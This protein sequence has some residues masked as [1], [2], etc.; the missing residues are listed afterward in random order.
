M[1][2]LKHISAP[3]VS[4]FPARVVCLLLFLLSGLQGVAAQEPSSPDILAGAIVLDARTRPLSGSPG[5]QVEERLVRTKHKYPLLRVE[6]RYESVGGKRTLV[7]RTASV[8]DHLMVKPRPGATEAEVLAEVGIAGAAVRKKM[9]TSGVWLVSFPASGVEGVARA[10]GSGKGGRKATAYAEPDHVVGASVVPNDPGFS[11]LWGLRN[12]GAGWGAAGVDIRATDAWESEAATGSLSVKVG[13]IDSGIDHTHPDLAENIWVNPNEI[14][15]NGIDDDNNGYIDDVRGWNFADGNNNAMD[16]NRHGTHVAG[17]IGGRGNNGAGV[18]GVCWRV[19][20][21]PLKFL[22]ADGTGNI[23]DAIEAVA[24]A[25]RLGVHLTNNSWGGGS[26]SQALKDVIDAANAAGILFVAAAGNESNDNDASP[27]YPASYAC[28]N[29]LSVAS[30]DRTGRLSR[31]SNYGRSTVHLGAP[32]G[33]I[34]STVP[35]G[36]YE[37]LSGTSMAAPHVAG[38]CALLKSR[39]PGMSHTQIRAKVLASARPMTALSGKTVTGAMLDAAAAV[40]GAL[41]VSYLGAPFSATRG[42]A[43]DP[44]SAPLTLV[45]N[46]AE[47]LAWRLVRKPEWLDAAPVSGQL[48]AGRSAAVVVAPNASAGTLP[49]G[50]TAGIVEFEEAASGARVTREVRVVVQPPAPGDAPRVDPVADRVVTQET[51]VTE[52]RLTGI[53][54]GQGT[55]GVL[56]TAASSRPELLPQPEVR[57][58]AGASEAVLLLRPTFEESGVA[59]V[60]VEV[61]DLNPQK[62]STAISFQVEVRLLETVPSFVAAG[63][64]IVR[65][66]AGP[67]QVLSWASKIRPAQAGGGPLSFEVSPAASPLFAVQPSIS[68]AGA[69]TYQWAPDANGTAKFEVRLRD[70]ANGAVSEPRPLTLTARPVND[71]PSFKLGPDQFVARGAGPQTVPGWASEIQAGPPDESG[72]AVRFQLNAV[73]G[74]PSVFEVPPS[75]TPDGTLRYTPIPS[76]TG[77]VRLR[78]VLADNAGIEDG[79][80]ARSTFRFFSIAIG[81]NENRP[82]VYSGFV[83]PLQSPA[84]NPKHMG[85]VN[86]KLS[87]LGTFTGTLRMG[88]ANYPIRGRFDAAGRAR[89]GKQ[90]EERWVVIRPG[91]PALFAEFQVDLTQLNGKITGRIGEAGVAF[92]SVAADRAF[93][94]AASGGTTV[95]PE[96][97]GVS[98]LV[99]APG[100]DWPESGMPPGRG[101]GELRVFPGGRVTLV[102]K[103]A[104]GSAV[105]SSAT[106]SEEWRWP[107]F[108]SHP[109]GGKARG[110]LGGWVSPVNN[111]SA[112]NFEASLRWFRPGGGR[113]PA[114]WPEGVNLLLRDYRPLLRD[115]RPLPPLPD[116]FGSRRFVPFSPVLLSDALGYRFRAVFSQGGLPPEGF[117]EKMAVRPDQ[118][119]VVEGPNRQALRVGKA[120]VSGRFSGSFV[121]P[122]SRRK[123]TFEGVALPNRGGAVGFFVT[124]DSAGSLRFEPAE[125]QNPFAVP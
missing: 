116:S 41:D 110:L 104:D 97:T 79:G 111:S 45:N 71:A 57:Y 64:Q 4:G 67:Q 100:A 89:F 1:N 106:L 84:R 31:F 125:P 44:A 15:G 115:Y 61:A 20:M 78:V 29:I 114:G 76:A 72:Q 113:Y 54:G 87:R 60:S 23:S 59:Q 48:D 90:N 75:I 91:L 32:G 6:D 26:Y 102:G 124:G 96:L 82:G 68:A 24:Y 99:F 93:F 27:S 112:A 11:Q 95:P 56:I 94:S 13:V 123:V 19:S 33:S 46:G 50:T 28:P 7:Q 122:L 39:R 18:A 17:T 43:F 105:S 58:V 86:F 81:A 8:A 62:G 121:H 34:Y 52:V 42:G 66:D 88:L 25:T 120:S 21:V 22:G 117:S 70:T 35:G 5:A 9:P 37:T 30:I 74:D 36:R 109:A 69:L 98:S 65:E 3:F 55:A 49:P 53:A 12:T 85:L 92:A 101:V 38:V 63:G 83:Q 80:V 103:L 108:L 14:P 77:V 47:T 107:L 10:L 2:L 118:T 73:G 119:C 40:D 51:P 16:D